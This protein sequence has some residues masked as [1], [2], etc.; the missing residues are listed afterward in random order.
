MPVRACPRLDL[1]GL[2]LEA[3][4]P[5]DGERIRERDQAPEVVGPSD[6]VSVGLRLPLRDESSRDPV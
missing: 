5:E 3:E 6:L 4:A 1:A 2:F